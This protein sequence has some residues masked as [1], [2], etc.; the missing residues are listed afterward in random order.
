[1]NLIFE[2]LIQVCVH[3][4]LKRL[5]QLG[6]FFFFKIFFFHVDSYFKSSLNVLQH[7]LFHV[8]VF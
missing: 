6:P 5:C 3:F 1:M 8:L 7:Y 2:T 4:Y